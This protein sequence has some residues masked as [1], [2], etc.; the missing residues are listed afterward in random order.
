MERVLILGAG[1]GGLELATRLSDEVADG[2][3]VTLIDRNDA[4]VFG[5]SKLDVMFGREDLDAVRLRY[6]DIVKPS[7]AVRQ[8]TVT[9][10]DPN[11]RHVTTDRG[12]YDCD[13]LVVA[14]GADYAPEATPGLLEGGGHEFYSVAG[15]AAARRVVDG[16]RGGDVIIGVLGPFFKCPV[17]P[18]ETAIMLH[19][20]FVT[21]GVRDAT[22]IT[23]LSPMGAPIP[24]SPT[25][26]EAILAACGERGIEF[27]ASTVVTGLDPGTNT[28]TLHDGGTVRYDLFLAVP[29]HK[30]PD[31][32]VA[33]GLAVDG[34]IPVD[35]STF[36]TSFP[37]VYAVGD[38]TSAPV[39]RAGVIAE[40]EAGTVADVLVARIRDGEAPGPYQGRAACYMEFGGP[41]V[42]RFDMDFL[43]GPVPT[44]EFVAPSPAIA[45]EK[46]RFGAV[47]RRRWFGLES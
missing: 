30:A 22:T 34:W 44:G 33:S 11:T 36:A 28:A 20:R 25:A 17:A 47:R 12:E 16:F 8:E 24:I 46:R 29:V 15:A 6:R 9:A 37:G 18:F 13:I 38:V 3:D 43:G 7:V 26:S 5:F 27:H 31:V 32:V 19:D 23:I 42:A 39:P 35:P 4:F 45:E 41:D 40:G 14:L 21:R 2:V 10:I 1:F